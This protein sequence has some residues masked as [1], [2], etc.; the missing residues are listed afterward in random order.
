[1]S[2]GGRLFKFCFT[3]LQVDFLDICFLFVGWATT[4]LSS[5]DFTIFLS[6]LLWK[7]GIR[8]S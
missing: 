1:L 2:S 5:I 7:V 4:L 8:I 6:S 3:L